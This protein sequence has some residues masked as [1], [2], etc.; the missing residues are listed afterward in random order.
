MHQMSQQT[1]ANH[2]PTWPDSLTAPT[3]EQV[4]QLLGNFWQA[5]T[6]LPE[7]HRRGEQLLMAELNHELRGLILE[8]ML[9]LNGIARPQ[10][11]RHLNGY[12]GESQRAAIEA[13]LVA[14]AVNGDVWL[15]QAVALLV[16]Y[17]WYA[18]QLVEKYDLTY[19]QALEETVWT[20]LCTT[21]PGWPVS[22]T[23]D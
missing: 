23:T 22:V 7:L 2:K 16:I 5:L 11:T 10:S 14:P 17:R 6:A 15:G 13:T 21:L 3:A 20:Q 19:P 8:M 4:A 1:T 18:P 9:A 12:L